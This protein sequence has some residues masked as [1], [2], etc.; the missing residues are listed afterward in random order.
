MTTP[1]QDSWL[2]RYSA[3]RREID[4]KILAALEAQIAKEEREIAAQERARL[5]Q[6]GHSTPKA[7]QVPQNPGTG[8]LARRRRPPSDRQGLRTRA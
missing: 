4:K 5:A 1:H 6:D 3:R 7:T 8:V 2:A